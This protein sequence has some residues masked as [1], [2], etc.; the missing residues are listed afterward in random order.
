MRNPAVILIDDGIDPNPGPNPGPDPP[1]PQPC[2]I[3]LYKIK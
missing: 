1:K 2:P 3:E